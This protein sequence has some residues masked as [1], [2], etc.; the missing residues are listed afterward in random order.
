MNLS[1][2]NQQERLM[3]DNL[4]NDVTADVALL[5]G[6]DDH[7][8][9]SGINARHQYTGGFIYNKDKLPDGI[10][11]PE[12]LPFKEKSLDTI[13]L[14]HILSMYRFPGKVLQE[15]F[16]S[17]KEGGQLVIVHANAKNLTALECMLRHAKE[18]ILDKEQLIYHHH[19]L[20]RITELLKLHGFSYV[21]AQAILPDNALKRF[22]C[23]LLPQLILGWV[24]VYEKQ[25][26][27]LTPFG[28]K[29][30]VEMLKSKYIVNAA[31]MNQYKEK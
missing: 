16:F 2:Y 17:L 10:F 12:A 1:Q 28:E 21:N 24:M 31:T 5:I 25:V 14:Y 11:S 20:R 29:Q 23:T 27:P 26:V 9:L 6:S 8:L 13:V 22:F 3:L 19:S 7:A 15:A 18:Q 30:R 4:L